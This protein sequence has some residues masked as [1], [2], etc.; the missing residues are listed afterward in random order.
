MNFLKKNN[1]LLL[2]AALALLISYY[3]IFGR[4]FP[5]ESGKLGNDYAYFLP[6]LLD[7]YFWYHTNGF[8]K[9]PWFT[10]SF[11][12]GWP[13]YVNVQSCFYTIPQLFTL[14]TDPLNAVRLTF[15]LFAG[16]GFLGF[17]L[18]L[19][20]VFLAS[21]PV[22][23]LGAGLFLFNGFYSHRMLSGH[24]GN[25]SFML[26]PLIS[27]VFLRP[28]PPSKKARLWQL[29]FD[30]VIGGF[31]IAYMVQSGFGPYLIPVLITI[32]LIALIHGMLYG[33]Q[34]YFWLRWT[35][36]G[37]TSVLLCASKLTAIYY[38]M[39]NFP[40]STYKLPGAKSFLSATWL[41]LKSL[42]ISPAF[43]ANRMEMLTNTQWFIER[44]ELE[45]SVTIVPLV[46]ILYG[47]W[48]IFRRMLAK[49]LAWKLNWKQMLQACAIITLLM[50]PVAIN[51]YSPDWNAFLKKLP[52][53]KSASNLIRW[54]VIYIPAIILAASLMLEKI[55]VSSKYKVGIVVVSIA[56]V[57][58]FNAFV[59]RD[60]Y[61]RRTYDPEK[62]IK[63][64][65]EVKSGS[66]KPSIKQITV[67]VNPEGEAIMPI[68]R[69]DTL[70]HGKSQL[71]CYEALFGYRLEHFPI[72]KLQ[73]GPALQAEGGILNIKNPAC[74]VW[75]EANN[76]EPGDHFT[77]EQKDAAKAF[78][79]YRP[80]H[81]KIP[82]V[83]QAANWVNAL[84]LIFMLLF[85]VFYNARVIYSYLKK[86]NAIP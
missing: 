79:N 10:P 57:V 85:L 74:Y 70:V 86:E 23:L 42:F 26:L 35:G 24:F 34:W 59:E 51:T 19:R 60:F 36:A 55:I 11:C 22:S 73:P 47:L 18:L 84:A 69:N 32:V 46:I 53:I 50:L 31:L 30:S 82:I 27:F 65:Y 77:K 44:H 81:F 45:Y 37:F 3:A 39:S 29:L 2:A 43:D 66:W 54:F 52:I 62:I 38:L 4:F 13:N 49:D 7:G 76:C 14:L 28:L 80:F 6:I 72:K 9:I 75:P 83:Q 61:K 71:L 58:A 68:F 63:S 25:Y 67:Y 8:W 12:G 48:S 1:L 21:Q 17:Y 5:N 33:R 41:M 40:R 56:T 78:V 16:L 15:V 64:Y 20:R